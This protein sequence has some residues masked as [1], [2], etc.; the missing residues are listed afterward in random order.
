M[1]S[2]TSKIRH[3]LRTP[4]NHL[5]GYGEILT[6]ML[7]DQGMSEE[8]PPFAAL[9]EV[10][11]RAGDLVRSLQT[12]PDDVF[13]VKAPEVVRAASLEKLVDRLPS[14]FGPP[15]LAELDADLTRMSQA[16]R[17]LLELIEHTAAPG[18]NPAAPLPPDQAARSA[19]GTLLVVDDDADNREL[20]RRML[21]RQGYAVTCAANGPECLERLG[22]T[23]FDLVLLDVMMPGMS[24]FDVLSAIREDPALR[25]VPVIVISGLEESDAAIRCIQMGAEDYLPKP[26]DPVL[27]KARIGATLEKK[28]LRDQEAKYARDLE[29]AFAELHGAKDRLVVQEKLASLGALTAGIAHELKNPLNFITNFASLA[30]ETGVELQQELAKGAP[31]PK[32]IRELLE[33]LAGNLERIESHGK[34]ADRIV[35]GMLLHSHG[36]PGRREPSDVNALVE[37]AVNLAYHGMRAH[38]SSFNV[39]IEKQLDPGLPPVSVVPQDISRVFVN[40]VANAFYATEERKK[41][42]PA[43]YQPC[44]RVETRQ[45]ESDVEIVF[46]DNGA[47]I[48]PEIA[49][50]IFDPFF[51]TKPAGT[52]TGLGLSIS[53]DIV[54]RAHQGRLTAESVPGAFTRFRIGLPKQPNRSGG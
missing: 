14:L 42:A 20:L 15:K 11:V 5:I 30:R 7:A 50:K 31:D 48:A 16:A 8:E 2:A 10:I 24:G 40:I 51:T 36:Q 37:E 38:D 44:L 27:L 25:P 45:T 3:D 12:L 33:T 1:N 49:G 17:R 46:E 39:T 6:E 28:R 35:R 52:G 26:F 34:R 43:G 23:Q 13:S 22:R 32:E 19:A 41:A 54:V 53:Y 47:G 29:D 9:K 4:L 18:S 21:E